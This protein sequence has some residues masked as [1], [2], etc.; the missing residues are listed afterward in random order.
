MIY[1]VSFYIPFVLYFV[2]FIYFAHKKCTSKKSK[3]TI[4]PTYFDEKEPL[5][6]KEIPVPPIK[7]N[8]PNKWKQRI[9]EL[10][11]NINVLME[12]NKNEKN[13]KDS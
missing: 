6:R 2:Y 13:N 5:H 1:M 8:K 3:K 10:E 9:K 7:P 12:L 11:S 4:L